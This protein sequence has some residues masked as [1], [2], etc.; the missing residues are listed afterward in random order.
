MRIR[1]LPQRN[2]RP[3]LQNRSTAVRFPSYLLEHIPR[4]ESKYCPSTHGTCAT[5]GQS[6]WCSSGSCDFSA[7]N[8]SLGWRPLQSKPTH[9]NWIMIMPTTRARLGSHWTMLIS[10]LNNNNNNN[11]SPPWQPREWLSKFKWR[12]SLET[13]VHLIVTQWLFAIWGSHQL[14]YCSHANCFFL[15]L[16][17]Y[18]IYNKSYCAR[19]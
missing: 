19:K 13:I 10:L 7:W 1:S 15:F 3:R 14:S 6:L 12:F 9:P 4:I 8:C 2:G 11:L 18:S 5:W 16:L 17:V